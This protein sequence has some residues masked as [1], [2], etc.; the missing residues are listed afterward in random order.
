MNTLKEI[1]EFEGYYASKDGEIYSSWTN[2]HKK[3]KLHKLKKNINYHGYYR[4]HIGG[5][6]NSKIQ[7]VHR[8]VAMAH[9]DNPNKYTE[10]N[11][12]DGVKTNNH[13][14][15]LEWCTRS[16][17]I[18]H[19]VDNNLISVDNLIEYINNKMKPVMLVKGNEILICKSQFDASR[20]LGMYMNSVGQS[21]YRNTTCRGYT[22]S[23]ISK[24]TYNKLVKII[25]HVGGD[26]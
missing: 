8:L 10:I 11:H 7:F 3:G 5:R 1:P 20:K 12:I 23:N 4:V 26:E 25:N 24:E 13:I 16:H 6:K 14:S 19:A 21:I 22:A 2:R 9:I 17:N 18:K 15:N